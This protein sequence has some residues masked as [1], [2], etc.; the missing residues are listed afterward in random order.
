[1]KKL[2]T[3]AILLVFFSFA[4]SQTANDWHRKVDASLLAK[5][6][7]GQSMPFLILLAQQADVSAARQ[8][9][10]KDEKATFVFNALRQTAQTTQSGITAFLTQKNAPHEGFFIINA[11]K[12]EGNLTLINSLAQR[13]DV[14]QILGNPS[15]HNPGPVEELEESTSS[16]SAVEWGIDMI[17][18]DD[19][20][21]LGYRGQGVTVAGEDTGYDWTHPAIKNKYRGYDD[22]TNIT[23][24]NYNWHDAIHV[25]SPLASDSLNPCGLDIQAPC[26]DYGHGTHT[27]GTMVGSDGDYEIGVAPDANWC[28]CRNME[29]GNGSPFTYLECFQWFL[30]PTDLNNENPDPTKA[31]HVINNSWYCSE[32]EGCNAS[33]FF[34]LNQAVN[35]LRLAGTVVV[36]SAGNSGSGCGSVSNPP[37]FYENSFSIGATAINDTIAGFSSRGPVT[38]DGS[39]RLKPNVSAPGVNV[40]SCVPGG[41]YA[42]YSGTSM[43]GP[44][45]AGLV[46]LMISANPDL[47]G[48]VDL[49]EDIIEQTAVPKTTDQ[50]CGNI[51]GTEVPNNTYGFGRVDAL[52]AVEAALA[53]IPPPPSA[54]NE[55]VPM[56]VRVFPNPVGERLNVEVQHAVG[57]AQLELFDVSG[58][59]V[60]LRNWNILSPSVSVDF[61]G[62][63]SGLYFYRLLSGGAVMQG[64]VV[65]K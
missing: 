7:D 38:M 4:N 54:T 36:V 57:E 19:V 43:A 11:I 37:A 32:G 26:D 62:N 21:A 17:N 5:T 16:R 13:P 48:Q 61:A 49:I 45:V 64:K 51:L 18:A 59:L 42:N 50:N 35:S 27:M 1:M 44:H 58:R 56:A 23:D 14:A 22:T 8:L 40:R 24:H 47:A 46:A 55:Q 63:P 12:T 9:K 2:F 33:N 53:L 20:W 52:A 60:L 25:I 3:V 28:A 29:R 31:P 34:V 30:A 6:A 41:A 39:N 10:T 65:K 15:I